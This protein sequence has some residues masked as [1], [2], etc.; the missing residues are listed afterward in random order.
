MKNSKTARLMFTV[1]AMIT[2]LS[3]LLSACAPPLAG[4]QLLGGHHCPSLDR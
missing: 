2:V 4:W 1:F 3:L